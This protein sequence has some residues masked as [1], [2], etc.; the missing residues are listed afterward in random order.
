M[1]DHED[2]QSCDMCGRTLGKW[3]RFCTVCGLDY[4]DACDLTH[5]AQHEFVAEAMGVEE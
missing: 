3:F 1:A 5:S 4:C 2:Y